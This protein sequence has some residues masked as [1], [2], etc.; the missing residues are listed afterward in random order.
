MNLVF[1]PND[2]TVTLDRGLN[3]SKK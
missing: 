1:R 2:Q 3:V